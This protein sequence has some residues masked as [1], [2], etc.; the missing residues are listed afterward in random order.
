MPSLKCNILKPT[1]GQ[2]YF[3]TT[4]FDNKHEELYCKGTPN[5]RIHTIE[6]NGKL[7]VDVI[8]NCSDSEGISTALRLTKVEFV[9]QSWFVYYKKKPVKNIFS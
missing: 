6:K 1:F 7:S 4:A 3:N 2:P 8:E 9:S 5:I